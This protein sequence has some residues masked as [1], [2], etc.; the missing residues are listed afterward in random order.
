MGFLPKDVFVYSFSK[1]SWCLVSEFKELG[2]NR[3]EIKDISNPSPLQVGFVDKPSYKPMPPTPHD[4]E[5]CLA[6]WRDFFLTH[7]I[8]LFTGVFSTLEG[9]L[10]ENVS[11][12]EA[13]LYQN[14]E[15]LLDKE[16]GGLR[17]EIANSVQSIL[18]SE[19]V[20]KTSSQ[21]QKMLEVIDKIEMIDKRIGHTLANWQFKQ[22]SDNELETK[23]EKLHRELEKVLIENGELKAAHQQILVK[24]DAV[25]NKLKMAREK[26]YEYKEKYNDLLTQIEDT[27]DEDESE[28][29]LSDGDATRAIMLDSIPGI[30]E[31]RRPKHSTEEDDSE[32]Q[33]HYAEGEYFE[34]FNV[35]HWYVKKMDPTGPYALEDLLKAREDGT[36]GLNSLVQETPGGIWRPVREFVELCA[37][38]KTVI[39][40]DENGKE[41]KKF[42][43]KR[44]SYRASFYEVVEIEFDGKGQR[45]YCTSLSLGGCFVEL[46]RH[47]LSSFEVG[48]KGS[49]TFQDGVLGKSFSVEIE[50]K[51]V[52]HK[53]PKGVGVAFGELTPSVRSLIDNYVDFH[54]K[55]RNR[56]A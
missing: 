25:V 14:F 54:L 4:E 26:V 12:G 22:D 27:Q 42:L 33:G 50:I 39:N 19:M 31:L 56:A 3:V 40:T 41:H 51:N 43:V 48:M 32:D 23:N 11:K 36:L 6:Y 5:H 24:Y 37:P 15:T 53:K 44:S 16:F 30:E 52:G 35:D 28:A 45:G 46:S 49:V 9:R 34:A 2:T 55:Q 10:Q 8:E 47:E 7:S 29:H 38:I 17:S 13:N 21:D 20:K 18:K 1:E